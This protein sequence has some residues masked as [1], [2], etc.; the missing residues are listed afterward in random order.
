MT[1]NPELSECTE[2]GSDVPQDGSNAVAKLANGAMHDKSVIHDISWKVS[3]A[4]FAPAV[5][6]RLLRLRPTR[7]AGDSRAH[8]RL[9]IFADYF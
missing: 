1:V 5:Q 3:A 2:W 9:A 4:I 8:A 7:A 6:T